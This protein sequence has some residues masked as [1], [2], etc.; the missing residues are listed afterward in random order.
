MFLKKLAC[1]SVQAAWLASCATEAARFHKASARPLAVL[2]QRVLQEILQKSQNSLFGRRHRFMSDDRI[3]DFQMKISPTEYE[4]YA[5]Y[6]DLI[7]QGKTD[8]LTSDRVKM[9]ELT[10]GSTF[11]TKMIP[12]TEGLQ[13]S[14]NRALHPWLIDLYF[15]NPGLWGGPAYWVITPKAESGKTTSGGIKIGFAADSEYFGKYGK[16]LVELLMAV[17]AS[18]ATIKEI[19]QWKFETI[20]CLLCCADLRLIS[21][22][23]PTLIYSLLAEIQPSQRQIAETI[24][25]RA[26]KKRALEFLDAA[27]ALETSDYQSFSR[28]MWPQLAL[29]SS[30]SEAEATNDARQLQHDFAQA[31]FQTKGILATEAPVTIP[32]TGAPAPVLAARSAFFEFIEPQTG[33]IKLAHQLEKGQ[34]YSLLITTFGGLFRYRLHDLVKVAGWWNNLPCLSFAGKEAIIVDL[35]GEKLNA[36]HLK[37]IFNSLIPGADAAFVAPERPEDR[38]FPFYCLFIS[39]QNFFPELADRFNQALCENFH[40]RWCIEN[41]QLQKL[42]VV[43]LPLNNR[44]LLQSRLERMA[45]LG[46]QTSTAKTGVLTRLDGWQRWFSGLPGRDH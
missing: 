1:C 21:L 12:Y 10:S 18:A 29:V 7:A 32:I 30:W 40:Y 22:W 31:R 6:I 9:F 26:G 45:Q 5:E 19:S 23:N 33:K 2:Q 4:G 39:R 28:Q 15:N 20:V 42:K 43:P 38:S 17:P 46:L 3:Q 25:A 8:I 35:C 11:A 16:H 41:G 14:F 36:R 44:E 27:N 34:T 24:A 37:Q 13:N